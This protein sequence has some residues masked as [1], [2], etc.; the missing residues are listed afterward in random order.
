LPDTILTCKTNLKVIDQAVKPNA[1]VY[2]IEFGT[3][4]GPGLSFLQLSACT[5]AHILHYEMDLTGRTEVGVDV[6]MC[7][8]QFVFDIS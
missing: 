5:S 6:A 8:C 2:W 7:N 3:G 4:D 1:M